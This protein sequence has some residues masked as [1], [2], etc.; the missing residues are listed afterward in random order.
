[1]PK[2]HRQSFAKPASTPHHSL[3][4]SGRHNDQI[5]RSATSV[6][7]LISHLR[8]TQVTSSAEHETQA[9][10]SVS[11]STDS[12]RSVHPSLRDILELPETAPPRPRPNTRRTAIGG[13]R[14][15]IIPGPPPPESWLTED[16][17]RSQEEDDKLSLKE[18]QK[19]IYRLERLP[20]AKFPGESSL[21]HAILKSMASNWAWHLE[22]DGSFLAQ[23]PY[24][25]KD[26]L[27]SY[28]AVYAD[29]SPGYLWRKDGLMRGSIEEEDIDG[30]ENMIHDAAVTRLDFSRALGYWISF[31]QIAHELRPSAKSAIPEFQRDAEEIIPASW[32]EL[33]DSNETISTATSSFQKLP[34]PKALDQ[35]RFQN[36]R[37][38][39]FAHPEPSSAKWDSL[40]HLLSRLPTITHLSL[41]HWPIPCRSSTFP[42]SREPN[43]SFRD[44]TVLADA[45]A[46]L[47]QLARSSYC[48]KWLDLEGCS[49]WIEALTY[50]GSDPD[51]REYSREVCGPE[52]NGPW[53]DI[54]WIGLG[55]GF[56]CPE[57]IPEGKS[58][59]SGPSQDKIQKN[60]QR[61]RESWRTRFEQ[62]HKTWRQLV[63]IRK[64][65]RGKWMYTDVDERAYTTFIRSRSS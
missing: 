43:D 60:L 33:V 5:Q 34:I 10:S 41:A 18:I 57:D 35:P 28:I 21:S 62:G 9:S 32:D 4:S 48:L 46:V 38:L 13:R 2:K 24:H 36:L 51:G 55:P 19:P 12:L 31:K 27:L 15:R 30:D 47:R 52:W 14:V 59:S 65:S 42:R 3:T 44:N 25:V 20:G 7:D 64:E 50:Q 49:E 56:E 1:M 40:I 26:V 54:E 29:T 23:L 58:S 11:R 37:Y 45:A 8:R 63:Q 22:Y 53:R 17:K 16:S 39:S 6:N 61:A